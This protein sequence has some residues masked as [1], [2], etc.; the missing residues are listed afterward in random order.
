MV[1]D[2]TVILLDVRCKVQVQNGVF[3][4]ES[5]PTSVAVDLSKTTGENKPDELC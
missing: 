2:Q 4:L 3:P 5:V 1:I